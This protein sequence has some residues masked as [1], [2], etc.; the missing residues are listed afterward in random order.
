MAFKFN[1]K[2]LDLPMGDTRNDSKVSGTVPQDLIDQISTQD[3]MMSRELDLIHDI[4][5]GKNQ[6]QAPP[7][8]IVEASWDKQKAAFSQ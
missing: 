5:T 6:S 8:L 3:S 4:V 2:M 1:V 7:S